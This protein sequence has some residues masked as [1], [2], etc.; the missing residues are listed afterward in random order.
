MLID[1][2]RLG[3]LAALTALEP[4]TS[5]QSFSVPYTFS[6]TDQSNGYAFVTCPLPAAYADENYIIQATL[7]NNNVNGGWLVL[8]YVGG[9]SSAHG[10]A[11][12]PTGFSVVLLNLNS[13]GIVAGQSVVIHCTT[14]RPV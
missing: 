2:S 12:T 1:F 7:Q 8:G 14:S 10:T 9:D 4:L 11:P 6:A 13:S 5:I 3:P